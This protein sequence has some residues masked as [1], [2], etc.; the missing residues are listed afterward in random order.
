MCHERWSHA[1]PDIDLAGEDTSMAGV[2]G[3]NQGTAAEGSS[4]THTPLS[5]RRASKEK[6][7]R[8]H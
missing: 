4:G 8:R 2:G 1:I 3:L 5:G 6:R 7:Q